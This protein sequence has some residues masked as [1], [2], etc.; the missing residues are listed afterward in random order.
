MAIRPI[1]ITGSPV[2]HQRAEEVRIFD[3]SLAELVDDMFYW[4]KLWRISD[5]HLH[6]YGWVGS[7]NLKRRDDLIMLGRVEKWHNEWNIDRKFLGKGF[8]AVFL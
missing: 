7:P 1:H 8:K 2:L 4:K 5:L 6:W 3:Q